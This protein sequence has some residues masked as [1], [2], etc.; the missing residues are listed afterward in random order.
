MLDFYESCLK[1]VSYTHLDVYKRQG[2]RNTLIQNFNPLPLR[3]DVGQL[4]ENFLM[5]ERRKANEVAGRLANRYFWRTYDQKEIDYVEEHGGV[6][7]GFE[8]KWQGE[9]KPATRRE[10]LETYPNA[11]LETVTRE[12][13]EPFLT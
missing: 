10:F 4:W 11:V 7:Y 2:V 9:M 13:F 12:N 3:N 8:F 6:L 5:V 1:S